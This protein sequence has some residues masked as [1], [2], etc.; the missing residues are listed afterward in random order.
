MLCNPLIKSERHMATASERTD[1]TV[2]DIWMGK[3]KPQTSKNGGTIMS[4]TMSENTSWLEVKV[5][6]H[7]LY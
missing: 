1:T 7:Q 2:S 4:N 3:K 5:L 6:V